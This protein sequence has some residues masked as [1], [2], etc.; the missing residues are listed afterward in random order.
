[1]CY[2]SYEVFKIYFLKGDSLMIHKKLL[3]SFVFMSLFISHGNI[4]SSNPSITAIMSKFMKMHV[5]LKLGGKLIDQSMQSQWERFIKHYPRAIDFNNVSNS[6]DALYGSFVKQ[7]DEVEKNNRARFQ[8]LLQSHKDEALL[9]SRLKEF[10]ANDQVKAAFMVLGEDTIKD[11]QPNSGNL[12]TLP[13]DNPSPIPTPPPALRLDEDQIVAELTNPNLDPKSPKA[14][15]AADKFLEV[16]EDEVMTR[17]EIERLFQEKLE[18]IQSDFANTPQQQSKMTEAAEA[19]KE[20]LEKEVR[21]KGP[22]RSPATNPNWTEKQVVAELTNPNLDP[23]SPKAV[24]A[25]RKLLD[26]AMD[27]QL[28]RFDIQSAFEREQANI[29]EQFANFPKQQPKMMEAAEVAQEILMKEVE[30]GNVN[31]PTSQPKNPVSDEFR[32]KVVNGG[33]IIAQSLFNDN[34]FVVTE[35]KINQVMEESDNSK[36]RA[37]RRMLSESNTDQEMAYLIGYV[38][39]CILQIQQSSSKNISGDA[40]QV[41]SRIADTLRALNMQQA[42]A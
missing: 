39:S 26:I 6:L 19:A 5:E 29:M 7:I 18:K 27:E 36:I 14:V 12:N 1:M 35:R 33:M 23:K 8:K 21:E 2:E 28:S 11:M 16:D 3:C 32:Q 10:F 13:T 42:R 24:E 34:I 25:A 20:I 31:E 30:E 38:Q 15:L 17:N 4:F 40:G 37:L 41:I 22:S 9:G